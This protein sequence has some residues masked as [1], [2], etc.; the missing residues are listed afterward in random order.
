MASSSRRVREFC[1][2]LR[3]YE[4][5]REASG[6]FNLFKMIFNSE[7]EKDRLQRGS[8]FQEECPDDS[9]EPGGASVGEDKTLFWT[10]AR[11]STPSSI[12]EFSNWVALL[13]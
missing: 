2:D 5:Q 13:T 6:V 12:R 7:I 11:A 8:C 1:K 10:L 3:W 9:Y 4:E